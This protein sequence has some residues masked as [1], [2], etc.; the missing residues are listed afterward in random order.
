MIKQL[1]KTKQIIINAIELV[2]LEEESKERE[3]KIDSLLERLT[4]VNKLIEKYSTK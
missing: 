4:E 2:K 3:Q 1:E